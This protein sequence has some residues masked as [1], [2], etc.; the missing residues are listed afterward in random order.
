M[1]SSDVVVRIDGLH[2]SFGHLEVI[3]ASTWRCTAA[4]WW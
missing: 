1:S 3:R 4:R 2:K